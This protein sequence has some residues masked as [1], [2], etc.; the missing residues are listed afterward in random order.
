MNQSHPFPNGRSAASPA[1]RSPMPQPNETVPPLPSPGP[2][3]ANPAP[4]EPSGRDSRGRFCRGNPGGP[5]NPFARKTAALR[6]ALL[7]TVTVEDLQAIVRRLLQK[8]K[9]G[10][11]AA[12]RLVLS[13]AIDKKRDASINSPAT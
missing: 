4:T 13:Y 1:P 7:D 2:T 9:E 12:A 10:D 11:V 6:Q 5:G 3:A 8:A